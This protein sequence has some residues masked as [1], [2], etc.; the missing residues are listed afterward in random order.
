MSVNGRD[1]ASRQT[2]LDELAGRIA[3]VRRPHPVRVAIDGIDAAGKTIL[4][5]EL[6]DVIRARGRPAIRSIRLPLIFKA[7]YYPSST[8]MVHEPPT[9][10]TSL[11]PTRA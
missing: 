1:R 8:R 2:V 7:G 5:D 11:K 6:A 10:P 4:A 3:A 9:A